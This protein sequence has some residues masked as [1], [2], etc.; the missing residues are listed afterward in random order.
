MKTIYL[1]RH[2]KSSWDDALLDDHDRP[3]APRGRKAAARVGAYLARQRP[4]PELVMCSSA[5]R[6]RQTC[7]AV[8]SPLAGSTAVSVREDFYHADGV[9]LLA[10]LRGLPEDISTVMMIGHN[11]AI[12]D[13]ASTLAGDGEGDVLAKMEEK[14]PTGALARFSFGSSWF[15]LEP[16]VAYLESFVIPRSLPN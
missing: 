14:F 10:A 15:E 8:S 13:L 3:L 2:A 4:Q 16:G 11:P 1:L 7:D 9:D 5:T 12:A 6:A